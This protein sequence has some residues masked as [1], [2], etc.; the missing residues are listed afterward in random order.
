MLRTGKR[1]IPYPTGVGDRLRALGGAGRGA[2]LLVY[3][4]QEVDV[5]RGVHPVHRSQAVLGG[6]EDRADAGAGDRGPDALGALRHLGWVDHAPLVVEGLTR[7]MLPV[8]V[9]GEREHGASCTTPA[10]ATVMT[11]T[12]GAEAAGTLEA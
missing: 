9:G 4:F 5:F 3:V 10:P 7:M 1:L 8:R 6:F 2:P 12:G 11:T